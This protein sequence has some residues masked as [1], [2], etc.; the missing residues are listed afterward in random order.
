LKL[1][2]NA[3]LRGLRVSFALFVSRSVRHSGHVQQLLRERRNSL[4]CQVSQK[5]KKIDKKAGGHVSP[6]DYGKA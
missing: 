3:V 2:I 5:M 1:F 6:Y 4:S